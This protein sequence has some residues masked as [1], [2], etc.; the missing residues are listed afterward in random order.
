MSSFASDGFDLLLIVDAR[1]DYEWSG[2]HIRGSYN[3]LSIADLKALFH[4]YQECNACVI[5]HC[6]FS[7]ERGPK[8]LQAFREYDR[9]VNKN[10]YPTLTF[11]SIFLLEGGYRQFYQECPDLCEGGYVPMRDEKFVSNGALRNSFSR[12]S[13][14]QMT[15]RLS[16]RVMISDLSNPIFIIN[17]PGIR[18]SRSQEDE[19]ITSV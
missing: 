17:S 11:P 18:E 19:L 9:Y 14:D 16:Q 1:F 3:V 10:C 4:E 6:E 8:M 2:G 7:Q 15:N 5:F 12:Y 13:N